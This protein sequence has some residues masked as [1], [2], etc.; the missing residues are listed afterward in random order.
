MISPSPTQLPPIQIPE[1][2]AEY[3]LPPQAERKPV[4]ATPTK[5]RMG[6]TRTARI[7]KA[8]LRPLLKIFY[9]LTSWIQKHRISSLGILLLLVMSIS[10]TTYYLTGELPFGIQHDPFNFDYKGGKGEGILVQNWLYALRDGD[11]TH[12]QLLEKD[13]SQPPDPTQLITQFSQ[14]KTHLTWGEADVIAVHQERDMTVDSFV[15]V[16]LTAKGPGNTAKGMAL[17]HFVTA[18]VNGQNVLLGAD[19]VSLRA[20]QS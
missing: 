5:R 17:F 16:P 15:E 9:Y 1:P 12:L 13:M 2:I 20:L 14:T 4:R 19:V 3:Q 6:E 10:A 8:I 11:M 7:I 18:S